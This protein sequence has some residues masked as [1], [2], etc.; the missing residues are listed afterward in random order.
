MDVNVKSLTPINV[1]DN[2]RDDFIVLIDERNVVVNEDA[3]Q[4]GSS[5]ESYY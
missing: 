3:Y 1:K 5:Y 4:C 2:C